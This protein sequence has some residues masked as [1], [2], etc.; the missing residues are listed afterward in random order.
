MILSFFKRIYLA[1]KIE[2]VKSSIYRIG[3]NVKF[4]LSTK[5][6]YPN[7]LTLG[8]N[9]YIGP[10]GFI[11]SMGE[12]RIGAGT[13]IGPEIMILS[14]NHNFKDPRLLPYDEQYILKSVV[15]EENVWIGARVI[16]TPGT[17]IGEGSIIGAGAVVRG[18]IPKMSIVTGNPCKIVSKRN[19]ETYYELKKQN[20]IYLKY[21]KDG[22]IKNAINE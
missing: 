4:D 21:K 8:D 7:K 5:F 17:Y 19:E 3:E 1:R 2:K 20:K 9:I 6:I 13:I 15:I 11:N 18:N 12:V 16:I 14:A 22:K 10:K